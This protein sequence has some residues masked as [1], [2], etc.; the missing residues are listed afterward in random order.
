MPS[1]SLTFTEE[2]RNAIHN[3][4]RLIVVIGPKALHSDYVRAEWQVALSEYKPVV[5]LLR[6]VPPGTADLYSCLPV[7]LRHF[8]A[9]SFIPVDGAEPPFPSLAKIL[10]EPVPLPAPI[11]GNVP[12][13]PA[14][15]RPRPD[16]FTRIFEAVL[17]ELTSTRVLTGTERV[18]VLSGMGGIGKTVLAASLVHA[19]RSRPSTFLAD[20]IYW[21]D[22]SPSLR[23]ARLSGVP[24]RSLVNEGSM[25]AALTQ[26]FLN[27]RFLLVI[28][29]A[30]S[31]DQIAPLIRILGP[32]GRMLV[33]TRCGELA[34]AHTSIHLDQLTK[35]DALRLVADW[36]GEDVK[37]LPPDVERV[38]ELCGFHP[39]ALSLNAAAASQGLPWST[40][41]TA[42]KNRE[43]DFTRHRF[44]EY[45]YE[46]VKQSIKV[47][48]DALDGTYR[49]AALCYR[50]LAAFVWQSGV[51]AS[52]IARF[53]NI[54]NEL[55]HH[56]AERL[57]VFLRQ[58]SLI[59]LRGV[60]PTS[61]V[62]LHDLHLAFVE[63][64][65][66]EVHR[67][68]EALLSTYRPSAPR[69]W[70]SVPDDGYVHGHLV[71]HLNRDGL[72]EEILALFAAEDESGANAWY[73]A[74][75]K[76]GA[77]EG[78]V[79][80][81]RVASR[82]VQNCLFVLITTSLCS[83]ARAVPAHLL[84]AAVEQG[85]W[86]VERAM[87]HA[88]L[89]AEPAKR[90]ATMIALLP[91]V[92]QRASW[93]DEAF[94][95]LDQAAVDNRESPVAQL[96]EVASET[97]LLPILR[98]V[99]AWL[100]E[101]DS[102][103]A[104]S[105]SVTVVHKVLARIPAPLAREA[106][107]IIEGTSLRP[108]TTLYAFLQEPER[109][110]RIQEV[111]EEVHNFADPLN[112]S[113]YAS[114]V[115]V[116]LQHFGPEARAGL[117][118]EAL[119]ALRKLEPGSVFRREGLIELLPHLEADEQ[120]AVLEELISNALDK[121]PG[122]FKRLA[123]LV[124]PSLHARLRKSLETQHLAWIADAAPHFCGEHREALV[125]RVLAEIEQQENASSLLWMDEADLIR[126]MNEQQLQRAWML[127]KSRLEG[128]PKVE[129]LTGVARAT[130]PDNRDRAITDLLAAIEEL[131]NTDERARAFHELAPLLSGHYLDDALSA[132]QRIGEPSGREYLKKMLP[133]LSNSETTVIE[134]TLPDVIEK[135]L[136][137]DH[138]R[139]HL[140]QLITPS[141][142]SG[143]RTRFE[144]IV[145]GLR[146]LSHEEEERPWIAA[147]LGLHMAALNDTATAFKLL[148][149]G[150]NDA[151]TVTALVELAAQLSKEQVLIVEERL[152]SADLDGLSI[153]RGIGRGRLIVSRDG[154]RSYLAARLAPSLARVG[155]AERAREYVRNADEE[156]RPAAW[157]GIAAATSGNIRASALLDALKS[158]LE[159]RAV[160]REDHLEE[161]AH[162]LATEPVVREEAWRTTLEWAGSQPRH[163]AIEV[164]TAFAP[165][166]AAVGGVAL[167]RDVYSAIERVLRWWP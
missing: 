10:S 108:L 74:R 106:L 124:P 66:R 105:R 30:T 34:T 24:P 104:E 142:L 52:A 120:E 70:W 158:V 141:Q 122:L 39:F 84:L 80:D 114:M 92:K 16:D 117:M 149:L 127:A 110:Q 166:S 15:F 130:S 154:A 86:S 153:P 159:P 102:P 50:E 132:A 123:K 93:L 59:E 89:H 28:D 150:R 25:I 31:A 62:H 61:E 67:L 35:P 146:A 13:L 95:A 42:L 54:Q 161:L 9:P 44:D 12:E 90:A 140:A 163:E 38:A 97:E 56:H 48:L 99:T 160:S 139:S 63:Q 77:F 55:P 148:L 29:N 72:T 79:E 107:Q 129:A 45:V 19:M 64:D 20:G 71:R 157:L 100:R 47:S 121:E 6:G 43:L 57:L 22:Q 26:R 125:E 131:D 40:I 11:V 137:L 18:T 147:G 111:L 41:V 2:I 135:D 113:I 65:Y 112:V 128:N 32:S 133:Y 51:P 115:A 109:S 151:V 17:G 156:W 49:D 58:R 87:A 4:D 162:A 152:Q 14:H 82:G 8:H 23:L 1:R 91:K 145:P 165:L 60:P 88:R 69:G 126:A 116:L 143:W 98:R 36:L 155:E 144:A 76:S 3:V 103:F 167:V 68:N 136:P 81:L 75:M 33:T 96:A 94:N 134:R 101:A 85:R 53:W 83:L 78:Y 73:A 37:D 118:S 119:A 138:A 7:E 27:K 46:T 5:T 21:L 164:L